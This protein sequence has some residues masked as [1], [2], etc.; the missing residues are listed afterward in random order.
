[1]WIDFS[2]SDKRHIGPILATFSHRETGYLF[3]TTRLAFQ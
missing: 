1:L 3:P 2:P